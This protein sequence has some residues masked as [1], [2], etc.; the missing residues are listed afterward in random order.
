M[1]YVCASAW[2]D[3]PLSLWVRRE[4]LREAQ[5]EHDPPPKRLQWESLGKSDPKQALLYHLC[6]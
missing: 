6:P 4:G 3:S 2:E 5:S 1:G